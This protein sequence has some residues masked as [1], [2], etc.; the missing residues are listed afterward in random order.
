MS[1]KNLNEIDLKYWV[2]KYC[3][4]KNKRDN[5]L[6]ISIG[7]MLAIIHSMIE[8]YDTITKVVAMFI[9]IFLGIVSFLVYKII[10]SD[11]EAMESIR[12]RIE[13]KVDAKFFNSEKY[14]KSGINLF[15]I[16]LIY[17][18]ALAISGHL[19]VTTFF[20]K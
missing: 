6:L 18:N 13:S 8:K 12:Q 16:I 2:D 4:I 15:K 11:V 19:L 7:G 1:N 5:N 10:I 20:N 17:F 9:S 14:I 3:E